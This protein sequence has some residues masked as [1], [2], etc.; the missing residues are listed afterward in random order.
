MANL[1]RTANPKV[2]DYATSFNRVVGNDLDFCRFIDDWLRNTFHYR[3]E[4][5]E[6][7]RTP[8]F[9]LTDLETLGYSEGD[10]DDSATLAC[11]LCHAVGIPSRLTAIA[12]AYGNPNRELQHV[13]A[14]CQT[15][16]GWVV[17]DPTVSKG[18]VYQ[19]YSVYYEP[20]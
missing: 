3:S 16:S 5:N 11:A 20:V 13:F 12:P 18:T 2:N 15:E 14:E 6:I 4:E 19:C 9:M 8:E 17:I 7:I 10:C 1:A